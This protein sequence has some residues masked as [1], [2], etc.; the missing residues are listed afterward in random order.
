LAVV[1]QHDTEDPI[2]TSAFGVDP[3]DGRW[4]PVP[5]LGLHPRAVRR[6]PG[7]RGL[8]VETVGACSIPT[9]VWLL[10]PG[11]AP[12]QIAGPDNDRL[13]AADPSPDGSRVVAQSPPCS[14]ASTIV[15]AHLDGTASQPLGPG[16]QPLW[17]PAP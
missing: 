15:V 12:R 9:G 10:A 7:N 8:L 2:D 17:S 11:Q 6:L 16:R 3:D 13:A 1:C 14:P 4:T 5:M